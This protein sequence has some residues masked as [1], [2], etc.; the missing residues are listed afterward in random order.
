MSNI[1]DLQLL[2]HMIGH[3]QQNLILSN[4]SVE[5]FEQNDWHCHT[6]LDCYLTEIFTEQKGLSIFGLANQKPL[7]TTMGDEEKEQVKLLLETVAQQQVQ[8]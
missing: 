6:L 1:F 8:M 2:S 7:L 3:S 5:P 4:K